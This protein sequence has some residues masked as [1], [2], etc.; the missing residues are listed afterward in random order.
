MSYLLGPLYGV[1]QLLASYHYVVRG[2]SMEPA[3]RPG[4]HLLV[5]RIAYHHRK[6]GRGDVVVM[7]DPRDTGKVYLKRIIALPGEEV[8][9]ADGSLFIDNDHLEEA[10]V[11]DQP[12]SLGLGEWTWAL[13]PEE[14]F[15]MGDNRVRST[16]SRHFGPVNRRLLVG[17]AWLRYWPLRLFG[18]GISPQ[19]PAEPP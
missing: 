12:A 19:E 13:G 18:G 14:Y 7:R 2:E 8:H 1:M 4:E 3:F 11:H 10:Y 9:I 15:V 6:P 5:N 16:D 17:K